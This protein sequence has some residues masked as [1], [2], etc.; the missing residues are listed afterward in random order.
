MFYH[1]NHNW[2][3][4]IPSSLKIIIWIFKIC[5]PHPHLLKLMHKITYNM[6]L[7]YYLKLNFSLLEPC[8]T[9]ADCSS[10]PGRDMC[11]QDIFGERACYPPYQ[12]WAWWCSK[13]NEFVSSRDNCHT[14]GKFFPFHSELN[15]EII[16]FSLSELCASSSDC[17]LISHPVCKQSAHGGQK[18]CQKN[19]TCTEKCDAG[20]LCSPDN[21][22]K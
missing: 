3:N 17:Y 10:I 6:F 5:Q 2:F 1:K 15:K 20:E 14:T 9:N 19:N 22:C 16:F 11:K 18:I 12:W 21:M 7:I 13:E 4:M 8:A